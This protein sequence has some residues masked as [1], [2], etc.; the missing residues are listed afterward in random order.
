[1][2]KEGLSLASSVPVLLHAKE[3]ILGLMIVARRVAQPYSEAELQLLTSIGQQIALAIQNAQLYQA[4]QQELIERKRTEDQLRESEER[5]RNIVELAP[6]GILTMNLKGVITT[7]NTAFLRLTGFSKDEIVGKHFSKL[8]TLHPQK[9]S[10]YVNM[11]NSVIR[12]K[13]PE[14]FSE[15]MWTHKDGT[16]RWGEAHVGLMKK[17][18]K[19]TGFQGIL[20]DIT[21]RKRAEQ[22]LQSL[23]RAALAMER[24]LTPEEIFT[25][26]AD[27]FNKLGFS[28]MVLPMDESRSRLFPKYLSYEAGALKAAERLMGL[29]RE[30]FSIPIETAHIYRKVVWERKTILIENTKEVIQQI[31]PEPVRKL[32][33]Q[34][35]KVLKIP[36]SISAPLVVEDRVIGVLSVQ[37]DD[38]TEPDIPTITAFAHQVAAAWRKAQL[39][40][41]AQQE[42]AERKRT[43]EERERLLIQN[44]EQAR[45]VRQ[46]MN[47]VP[48]GVLLLDSAGRVALA[49]P[50]AERDLTVLADAQVGD[51]LTGLG[52]HP[53]A[54]VLTS[55]PTES[56]WH[57]VKAAARTFE[58]IARPMENRPES[59]G[60]VLVTRDVTQEREVQQRV[61][62]QERLAAVGQLAAGIAHD[63]NNIMATIVLYAQ[64]V[65]QVEG[66]S[67]RD[68]ERMATIN[69]QAQHATNLIQQI[70][71][72]SRRSMLERQPLDLLLLLKEAVKLLERTLPEHITIDLDYGH[73][74]YTVNADLTSMQQMVT[75]LAVNARDAMSDGGKLRIGLERIE[76]RPGESPLLPEME[77][78]DWVQVTVADTGTGIPPNALPH[79]FEPFFTTKAPGKGS[80]LG[81]AQVYGIV[82]QHRGRIDVE[83]QVDE[84]TTFT[85]YLPAL[86]A[87]PVQPLTPEQQ[88]LLKGHGET[89]LVVEDN[90][91]LRG[92]MAETMESLNFRV[93]EAENGAEALTT[94]EKHGDE[95]ALVLSD[96]VMPEMGGIALFHALKQKGVAV[97]VVLM[98]GHLMW[99]ELEKLQAEGLS[100][101]LL[102][103]PS[104]E[105][106]TQLLARALKEKSE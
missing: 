48:E 16:T 14:P 80:G 69:Q 40:G 29:N 41:Q 99:D 24:A 25:A 62:R 97:P 19:I 79:I 72:F 5:Y 9:I 89:V 38:L 12:G 103:P 11:L 46:I 77:P 96:V 55:P 20:L 45:Q 65:A 95:I 7:C 78:G 30:D 92:A 84:G 10:Q 76:V 86:L 64:M 57:E 8:P 28:C 23:N 26:V 85:I 88:D 18:S 21:E 34:I 53:L 94:L 98:T 105:Q 63:F 44:Q 68:R 2:E 54:E 66:L 59:E 22:L 3:E 73:D 49:N 27:E 52:D 81:L 91:A 102:K 93:L 6:E 50:I 104:M 74:E 61:Q 87:Q 51:I 42:I 37:S 56:L 13:T 4:A 39:F 106:L 15:F 60:W 100:G 32:A 71:D 47:T 82:G 36:K 75:N 33:G 31:L 35:V 17:G 43:E 70:L 67:D 1:M 90:E 58:V 101:Y 83:T